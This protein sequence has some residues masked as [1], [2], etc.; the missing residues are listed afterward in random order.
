MAKDEVVIG[1]AVGVAFALWIGLVF[2][3]RDV[4]NW[5]RGA[6]LGVAAAICLLVGG[7]IG[8]ITTLPY[9]EILPTNGQPKYLHWR[10][11]FRNVAV[12]LVIGVIASVIVAL[13]FPASE[14][15]AGHKAPSSTGTTH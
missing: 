9:M 8:S 5:S 6:S 3:F 7:S 13:A 14:P 4:G 1:L 11:A 12:A 2:V 15:A 10:T